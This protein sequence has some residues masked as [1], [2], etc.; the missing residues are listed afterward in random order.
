MSKLVSFYPNITSVVPTENEQLDNIIG[1]IKSGYYQAVVD[2]VRNEKDKEK[3][4]ELKKRSPNFTVSGIFNKRTEQ[5]LLEHSDFIA[6]DIDDVEEI[7]TVFKLLCND[8]YTYS[9]FKSISDTGLC[10]IIKID[11]DK[12]RESFDSLKAYFYNKYGIIIDPSCGNISR[13]RFVSYDK[14]LYHKKDA[15]QF[16]VS[17]AINKHHEAVRKS[18][19]LHTSSKFEKLLSLIDTD[20][21]G[22]YEQWYRIGA[23]IANEYGEAG[24][25]YY[26]TIS[27]FSQKY[28]PDKVDKQYRACLKSSDGSIKI[29]TVYYWAKQHGFSVASQD[30]DRLVKQAY[31]AKKAGKDKPEP[32]NEEHRQ[33]IEAVYENNYEPKPDPKQKG[34]NI[35]D[36]DLWIRNAYEIRRNEITREYELNGNEMQEKHMN[37]IYLEAKTMFDKLNRELFDTIICSSRTPDYNPIRYYLDGLKYDGVDYLSD[38]AASITSDTGTPE[39]RK[40]MVTKWLLGMIETIYEGE[41]NIL[42]LILAGEKNTG[43][44]QFFKRLMP[45]PLRRFFANSQLDKGKDDE[46]L[47]TQKLMIFDDEYSGKSKQ[48]SKHMKR[49]LSSDTFTLREPYG[50]KNVTLKR[51][52]TLCGTCN[53]TEILNDATGNRRI[54]V[55]EATGQFNFELYNSVDKEQLFAQLKEMYLAGARGGLTSDEIE[56]LEQHTANRYGET[57]IEAEMLMHLF[58]EPHYVADHDFKTTSVIKDHIETFTKQKIDKRR[59]GIELRKMGYERI[60]KNRCYG[61]LI[62]AKA[63][64]KPSVWNVNQSKSDHDFDGLAPF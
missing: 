50:R 16:K 33:I 43:K 40:A 31:Y 30:E 15:P 64:K 22:D 52:A 60:Y 29:N 8:V 10:V 32:E 37:D 26:H 49:M 42:L 14:N 56:M 53:E 55:I 19:Y 23:G 9:C 34:V 6:I 39:W 41:P 20:I 44:T 4:D 3:K 25:N 46:V 47:M 57:S 1:G 28:E 13:T 21:T 63:D 48:D 59:L 24:L 62:S 58:E 45:E 51:I 11:G 5:G 7:D 35:N 54:I 38:L 17:R 36:V 61:Y 12:H 27:R 18:F 2:R